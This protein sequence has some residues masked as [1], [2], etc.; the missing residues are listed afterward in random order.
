MTGCG[1]S[2]CASS[3]D[4][5]LF[6]GETCCGQEI[7]YNDDACGLQSRIIAYVSAGMYYVD[8]EGYSGCGSYVL[9]VYEIV[10]PDNDLCQNATDAGTLQDC[11]P[12][13][14]E[15]DNTAPPRIVLTS[16][17]VCTATRGSSSPSR[18][19]R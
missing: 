13:V 17:A 16:V 5:Y 10:G 6:V 14:I 9:D 15:G 11:V 18:P 19:E 4:T 3:Y 7:G 2:R 8:I 1:P 12:V